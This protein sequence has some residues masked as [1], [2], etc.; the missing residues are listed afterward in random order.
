MCGDT[1][2]LET[3]L[4]DGLDVD[5]NFNYEGSITHIASRC[6]NE[7]MIR[8]LLKRYPDMTIQ[9]IWGNTPLHTAVRAEKVQIVK[10]LLEHTTEPI[11]MKNMNQC[12]PLHL[13][14]HTHNVECVKLLLAHGSKLDEEDIKGLMPLH[15]ATMGKRYYHKEEDPNGDLCSNIRHAVPNEDLIRLLSTDNM[16]VPSIVCPTSE[17]IKAYIVIQQLRQLYHSA[18]YSSTS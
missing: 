1:A 9:D 12:T 13:A 6:G 10:I 17:S 4:T 14:A 7:D 18:R 15:Y 8:I 3:L 2:T 16:S 11:S 5:T